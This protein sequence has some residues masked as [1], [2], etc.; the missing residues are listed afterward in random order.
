M[1]LCF[2]SLFQ[3]FQFLLV[4][5]IHFSIHKRIY[6]TIFT[7]I[8]FDCVKSCNENDYRKF[9]YFSTNEFRSIYQIKKTMLKNTKISYRSYRF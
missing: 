4:I 7:F 9:M 2:I 5:C 3:L 1:K 8:S 6:I